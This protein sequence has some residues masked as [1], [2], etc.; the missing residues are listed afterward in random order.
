[1]PDQSDSFQR[2]RRA[3]V[4]EELTAVQRAYHSVVSDKARHD[5]G[6]N[7][8][9]GKVVERF[10]LMFGSKPADAGYIRCDR[11]PRGLLSYFICYRLAVLHMFVLTSLFV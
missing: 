6:V 9:D 2:T 8:T 7:R 4:T 5:K 3:S 11:E 1:M 10:G